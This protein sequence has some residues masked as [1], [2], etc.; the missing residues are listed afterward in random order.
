M[1]IRSILM[2]ALSLGFIIG[3]IAL[4]DSA[5]ID[6][7]RQYLKLLPKNLYEQ[8]EV[9]DPSFHTLPEKEKNRT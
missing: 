5:P 1:K 6:K 4:A 7:G 8:P 9:L 2:S 3:R